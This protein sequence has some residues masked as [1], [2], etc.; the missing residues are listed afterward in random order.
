[1]SCEIEARIKEISR[2][3]YAEFAVI[4]HVV[5]DSHVHFAHGVGSKC[6]WLAEIANGL[7][8]WT[9]YEV[10]AAIY[11]VFPKEEVEAVVCAHCGGF[12]T[13]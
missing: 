6:E 7:A 12:Q 9:R 1:M 11:C 8:D 13:E 5:G 10:E 4:W 3:P 2:S